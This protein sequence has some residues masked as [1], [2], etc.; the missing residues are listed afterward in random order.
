MAPTTYQLPSKPLVSQPVEAGAWKA[1][2]IHLQNAGQGHV[3]H[4]PSLAWGGIR[5]HLS[6]WEGEPQ[7]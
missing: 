1:V 3:P 4:A 2:S 5:G 7:Y 6:C